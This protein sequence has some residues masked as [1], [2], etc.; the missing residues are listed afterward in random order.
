MTM[1]TFYGQTCWNSFLNPRCHLTLASKK[2]PCMYS[3]KWS[4][5]QYIWLY[6]YGL[7]YQIHISICDESALH[8]NHAS[9]TDKIADCLMLYSMFGLMLLIL[10]DLI[11]IYQLSSHHVIR[12]STWFSNEGLWKERPNPKQVPKMWN[13]FRFTA[14][15]RHPNEKI[16]ALYAPKLYL[17]QPLHVQNATSK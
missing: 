1:V 17:L 11:V 15:K 5:F 8:Y 16:G 14:N 10:I 4:L 7:S 2:V 9:D 12:S 13:Y 6:I 3:S